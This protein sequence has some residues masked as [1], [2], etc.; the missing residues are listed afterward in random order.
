[1][2]ITTKDCD[3][4]N[5]AI[6]ALPFEFHIPGYQFCGAGTHLEKR[7]IRGDRGTNPLDSTCREHDIT[8][9]RNKNLAK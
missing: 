5:H 1:M 3:F 8:Y 2:S 9:S 4:L 6:N 7:L